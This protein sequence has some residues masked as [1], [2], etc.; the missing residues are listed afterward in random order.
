MFEKKIHMHKG[1][2]NHGGII[3]KELP[4]LSFTIAVNEA[5]T[6]PAP[7]LAW[8]T[9]LPLPTS[10]HVN[11]QEKAIIRACYEGRGQVRVMQ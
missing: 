4:Q 6:P 7:P 3:W 11:R 5:S 1:G 2:H 8:L 10:K 9:E